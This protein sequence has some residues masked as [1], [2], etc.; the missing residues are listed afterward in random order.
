MKRK[1]LCPF[2]IVLISSFSS[3]E[4]EEKTFTNSAITATQIIPSNPFLKGTLGTGHGITD[5]VRLTNTI[6]WYFTDTVIVDVKDVLIIEPGTVIKRNTGG[7]LII[8]EGAKVIEERTAFTDSL[9][10]LCR[11]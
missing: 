6:V 9:S 2:F 10:L 5:T 7:N 1:S 4:K 11:R 8:A 3:C